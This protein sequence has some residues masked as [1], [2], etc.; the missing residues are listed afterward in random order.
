M[1]H[2]GCRT[3]GGKRKVRYVR[4]ASAWSTAQMMA[5]RNG[6][7]YQAYLCKCSFWHVGRP[8][9]RVIPPRY[10]T[11][12][13]ALDLPSTMDRLDAKD[14]RRHLVAMAAMQPRRLP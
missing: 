3:T 7:A 9:G 5:M 1:T 14:R 11:R 2:T 12:D 4:E 10:I 8:R 13:E 6:Q